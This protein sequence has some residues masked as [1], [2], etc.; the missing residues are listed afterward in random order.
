MYT[1][2]AQSLTA[3]ENYKL[4]IGSIIPRP[5]A[6]VTTLN[7]DASVN[8]APFSFFNI[9]NNHPPMIAIAVQRAGGKRKDTALNIERTGDFVVHITDEDNVQDIN[10][11]AA[12]LAYGDS[13]LSRTELS[14]LTST[15]IK[16]PGIKDAKMRF[17]CKLSQ[18]ILL[19]DVLDGA[20][21]IIGEIVT[22]HIDDSI[23]EGDFKINPHALQAVSRLAGN[24]YAKLWGIFTIKRPEK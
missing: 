22:Y 17:E 11:T 1:F 16:T 24:D 18:M 3:R 20:D 9:V 12:P 19:G 13:E 4:L 6:F 21:L 14:L 2:D 8:A 15:T 10:E 23:Y 5:I 7:Q